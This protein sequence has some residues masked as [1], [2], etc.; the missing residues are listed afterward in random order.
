V[1]I[2]YNTTVLGRGQFIGVTIISV[3]GDAVGGYSRLCT[4]F[5]SNLKWRNSLPCERLH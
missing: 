4:N 2:A 3:Y 5:Y 1:L